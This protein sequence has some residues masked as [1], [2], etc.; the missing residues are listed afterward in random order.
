MVQLTQRQRRRG[1][2]PRVARASATLL[3]IGKLPQFLGLV[4]YYRNRMTGRASRL[5]EYKGP[6]TV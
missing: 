2:E 4:S 3:M 6:E 1:L 5:I